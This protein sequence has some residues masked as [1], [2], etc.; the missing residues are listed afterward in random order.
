MVAGE[1]VDGVMQ[2]K[3]VLDTNAGKFE[4]TFDKNE[5]NGHGTFT[6]K[7]GSKYVGTFDHGE[8]S[9]KGTLTSADGG[10]YEGPFV[11]WLLLPH[12]CRCSLTLRPICSMGRGPIPGLCSA[13]RAST[14]RA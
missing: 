2:G 14:A 3:G 11:V 13:T 12:I 10:K 7:D 4:G 6:A 9:G 8:R 1:Y 5:I